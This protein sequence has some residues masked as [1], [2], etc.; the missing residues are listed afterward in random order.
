MPVADVLSSHIRWLTYADMPAVLQ[1]ERDC[2]EYG[3]WEKE[4]FLA[5][6][7]S[8]NSIAIVA[9]YGGDIRGFML[10]EITQVKFN[11]IECAVDPKFRNKGI[12]RRLVEK[13]KERLAVNKRCRIS[14]E[15]REHNL[16]AQLF[17]RALGFKAITT[18]KAFYDDNNE[19]A[20]RMVYRCLPST[21]S[22]GPC[23]RP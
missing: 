7:G 4:D 17:F 16:D 21:G 10:Y 8:Y 19:D 15:V 12:G 6:L 20:I 23:A 11:I 13:L 14:V 18:T 22:A 3:P 5:F 9:E 2:Y 1:I